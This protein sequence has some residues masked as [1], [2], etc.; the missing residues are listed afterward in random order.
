MKAVNAVKAVNIVKRKAVNVG[1]AG[2]QAPRHSRIHDIH[3]IHDI[4]DIHDIHAFMA[5]ALRQING[6]RFASRRIACG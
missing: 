5:F 3:A 6:R 1:T 2:L 4:H